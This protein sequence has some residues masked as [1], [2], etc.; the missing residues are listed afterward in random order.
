[1]EE[2]W[3]GNPEVSGS[4]PGSVKVFFANFSNYLEVPSQF[5]PC[6]FERKGVIERNV[7]FIAV[8]LTR[9]KVF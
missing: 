9:E 4:S 1:M 6:L 3:Y 2:C 7:L 5:F 8:V